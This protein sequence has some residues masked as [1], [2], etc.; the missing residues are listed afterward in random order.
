MQVLEQ[1]LDQK[2]DET[3]QEAATLLDHAMLRIGDEMDSAVSDFQQI[4]SGP[5]EMMK[6]VKRLQK[7]KRVMNEIRPSIQE[8]QDDLIKEV[9]K[10]IEKAVQDATDN[11]HLNQGKL[12]RDSKEKIRMHTEITRLNTEALRAD[13]RKEVETLESETTRQI[14]RSL[15][16]PTSPDDPTDYI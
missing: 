10:D 14:P 1:K 5:Q 7:Q 11:L 9:A 4:L 13:L 8:Q 3:F 6:H 15:K 2:M 12:T 16:P